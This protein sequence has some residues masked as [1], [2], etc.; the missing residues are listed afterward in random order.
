MRQW[1]GEGCPTVHSEGHLRRCD[2]RCIEPP[3]QGCAIHARPDEDNLLTAI[4]KGRFPHPADILLGLGVV[5]FRWSRRQTLGLRLK[6]QR[7]PRDRKQDQIVVPL[8]MVFNTG[9]FDMEAAASSAGWVRELNAQHTPETEEYGVS[10]FVFRAR[11]PFHPGRLEILTDETFPGVL[12]AK[13]FLWLATRNDDLILFS[14]AGSTMNF[15]PQAH[16]LAVDPEEEHD[17]ETKEY[18][19][20]IWDSVY[21]DRRQEIVFIGAGMDRDALEAGLNQALLTEEEMAS[22]PSVWARLDDPFTALFEQAESQ[23]LVAV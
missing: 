13:G 2:E 7:V 1:I 18:M 17:E 23:D 14:I 4:T 22:G 16:W 20:K 15:E 3:L 21:G 8:L 5:L 12:R 19:E 11:R 6:T 10:S 9:L